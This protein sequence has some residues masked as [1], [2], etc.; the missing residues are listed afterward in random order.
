M[1]GYNQTL[2]LYNLLSCVLTGS[3]STGGTANGASISRTTF[4]DVL[5]VVSIGEIYST[6]ST[7]AELTVSLTESDALSGPFT[8]IG[9]GAINGTATL[10]INVLA[11]VVATTPG[12][13]M[14]K[15]YEKLSDGKRKK[16]LSCIAT[17]KGTSAKQVG[18]AISVSLLLGR[19]S[20]TL[21]IASPV[22][23]GTGN[24]KY[25]AAGGGS[26]FGAV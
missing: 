20:D 25:Y 4:K 3:D 13:Y 10:N 9:N 5:M 1:R 19:P 7:P 14:G 17:L 16:F 18:G 8:V 22:S 15:L 24:T 23:I 6:A 2:E 26:Y 21:Y 12:N 11:G